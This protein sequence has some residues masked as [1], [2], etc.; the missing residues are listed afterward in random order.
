MRL[1]DGLIRERLRCLRDAQCR[2]VRCVLHKSGA[3]DTFHR[4]VDRD[5]GNR[6]SSR[7][8]CVDRAGNHIL[9]HESAR[10][11]MNQNDVGCLGHQYLEPGADRLLPRGATGDG[12]AIS[13]PSHGFRE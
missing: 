4:V 6:R 12:R 2:A 11:V 3:P 1:K 13:Q 5:H 9:C 8:C 7:K 10:G